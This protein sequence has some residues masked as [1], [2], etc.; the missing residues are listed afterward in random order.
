MGNFECTT[1]EDLLFNRSFRTWVL[2]RDSPESAFWENWIAENANKADLINRAKSIVYA[3]QLNFKALDEEAID[4]EIKKV[5]Q[6]LKDRSYEAEDPAYESRKKGILHLPAR[7]Y[8]TSAIAA[9]LIIFLFTG[10]PH[11]TG[12]EKSPPKYELLSAE[13]KSNSIEQVNGADT[14]QLIILPDGSKVRLKRKSKLTYSPGFSNSSIREVY[15]NG[16]AFFEIKR[17]AARPFFVLTHNII[18]KVLGTSFTVRDYSSDKKAVVSVK[19]GKVSVFKTGNLSA[20][21][22]KGNEPGGILVS[23]NQE[24]VYSSDSDEMLK[25][26]TE[27]PEL[28]VAAVKA[29]FTFNATPVSQVFKIMQEAYGIPIMYDGDVISTC[30]LSATMEEGSFYERLDI[31][32]KAINA[33]YEMVDGN[34]IITSNGCK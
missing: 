25:T 2:N 33:S 23:S 15:L 5:L 31:I 4:G 1:V 17:N 26:L 27:K 6:K 30:S 22:S 9:A 8:F 10:F 21:L 18:T 28:I 7:I 34:I 11:F 3:L 14:V 29:T 32:C 24:L 16:E 12:V 19:T 13:T 20:P